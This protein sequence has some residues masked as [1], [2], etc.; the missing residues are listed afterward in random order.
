[1]DADGKRTGIKFGKQEVLGLTNL[2][3]T[4]GE[5]EFVTGT[6]VVCSRFARGV[7]KIK[8]GTLVQ[9]GGGKGE[10]GRQL[11]N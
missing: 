10:G 2:K 3:A 9:S 1:M 4:N 6:S 11:A 5:G 8:L 7:S